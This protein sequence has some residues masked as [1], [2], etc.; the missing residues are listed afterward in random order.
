[1]IK[2]KSFLKK[3]ILF[4]VTI[5]LLT[6]PNLPV[7]SAV[8]SY[9][10]SSPGLTINSEESANDTLAKKVGWWVVAAEMISLAYGAGYVLGTLAHHAYHG[11]DGHPK[12]LALVT[13]EY[14]SSDFSQFDN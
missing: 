9:S 14:N 8:G 6:I 12:D 1:M 2:L 4:V 3:G 7:Y 11:M 5:M 10:T 13:L